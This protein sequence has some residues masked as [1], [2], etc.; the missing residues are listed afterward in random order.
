MKNRKLFRTK[1]FSL[2]ELL[3]AVTMG[4]VIIGILVVYYAQERKHQ[5]IIEGRSEALHSAEAILRIASKELRAVP[6]NT[7]EFNNINIFKIWSIYYNSSG[8][9]SF[10]YFADVY[11]EASFGNDVLDTTHETF[12]LVYNATDHCVYNVRYQSGAYVYSTMITGVENFDIIPYDDTGAI[13]T[14]TANQID[15]AYVDLI[16]KTINE[17]GAMGR[18]DTVLFSRRITIRSRM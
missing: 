5:V 10:C 15:V 12:G 1:G 8:N 6:S 17:R 3:A 13:V 4:A 18:A 14:D 7:S 2:I 16:V 9:D 11:P